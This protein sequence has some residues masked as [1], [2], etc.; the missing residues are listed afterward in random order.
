MSFP[1]FEGGNT[2][3]FFR[4]RPSFLQSSCR[5]YFLE[6]FS[7]NLFLCANFFFGMCYDVV[8][9]VSRQ[10]LDNTVSWAFFRFYVVCP[11]SGLLVGRSLLRVG[12][13]I[14]LL[15]PGLLLGP[16]GALPPRDLASLILWSFCLLRKQGNGVRFFVSDFGRDCH[17]LFAKFA[18]KMFFGDILGEN[19]RVRTSSLVKTCSFGRSASATPTLCKEDF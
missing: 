15:L 1:L 18:L 3:F 14:I 7:V 4:D 10:L 12:R 5:R 17:S 6:T 2:V 8:F 16:L 9:L 19:F 11:S 13:H